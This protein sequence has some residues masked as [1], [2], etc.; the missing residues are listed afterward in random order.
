MGVGV[1]VFLG[2]DR[3]YLFNNI[4]PGPLDTKRTDK[5]YIKLFSKIIW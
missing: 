1:F 4:H 5:S 3:V 2:G